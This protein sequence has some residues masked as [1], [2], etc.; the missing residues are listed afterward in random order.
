MSLK[1]SWRDLHFEV[2]SENP[3][4]LA[5]LVEF[6]APA[7]SRSPDH[8]APDVVVQMEESAQAFDALFGKGPDIRGTALE[9]FTLDNKT[10]RLPLWNGPDGCL[11]LYEEKFQ[12][13]FIVR[14]DRR[15]VRLLAKSGPAYRTPLMRI[16]REYVMNHCMQGGG[17]VFHASAVA[18]SGRGLLIVGA[19]NAG[20]TSL[21]THFLRHAG[22]DYVANDRVYVDP[23]ASS[24]V[25]RGIPTIAT[26]RVSMPALFPGLTEQMA[27][28]RFHHHLTLAE[29][30]GR[31]Q[32]L[33]AWEN[34]KYGLT[35]AQ[36]LSI[37]DAS[38]VSEAPALAMVFP[39][40]VQGAGS[41][42]DPMAAKPVD[43]R[44]VAR[45]IPRAL[46]GVDTLRNR[47]EVFTLRGPGL[48]GLQELL[49]RCARVAD[50]LPCY[51]VRLG[52]G[53]YRHPG[54]A[55]RTLERI[56]GGA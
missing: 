3:A 56:L 7:F 14:K 39:R 31:D 8:G 37:H 34:G 24:L 6:L 13:F 51:E 12:L 45:R 5:F 33:R 26:I 50:Q 18:V 48:P 41:G 1:L 44:E 55:D 23:A 40:V 20:K 9:A 47:A 16:L 54:A 52:E 36:L 29:C 49:D 42:A 10:I 43:H 30:E 46:F 4:D 22:A 21:M 11:T 2:H 35:P 17:V 15:H 28:S 32:P 19:S 53:S 27:A 38:A 25:L